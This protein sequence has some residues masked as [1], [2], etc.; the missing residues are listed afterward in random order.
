MMDASEFLS[1]VP[2]LRE[3]LAAETFGIQKIKPKTMGMT[4]TRAYGVT[5]TTMLNAAG[6]KTTM[7]SAA[8]KPPPP[9]KV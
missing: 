6:A 7:S 3:K 4:P 9:P 2:F 5:K 8:P 1:T